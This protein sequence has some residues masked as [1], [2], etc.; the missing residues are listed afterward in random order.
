VVQTQVA[1]YQVGF[2]SL[3]RHEDGMTSRNSAGTKKLLQKFSAPPRQHSR[4]YLD[5]MIQS[6]MVQH[7][8]GRMNCSGLGVLGT[9]HQSADARMH[10]CSSAHGTRL[11]GHEKIAVQQAVIAN[12]GAGL[13]QCQNFGV[14]G[15]IGVGQ[16]A[17]ESASDD[18]PFMHD[19]RAHW[20]FSDVE[21]SLS[22]P[23][24]LL[25]P[26]FVGFRTSAVPHN[27][28]CMRT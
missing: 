12:G 28:Y 1:F 2:R 3:S 14:G 4:T 5:P 25:H 10:D 27:Q 17:V 22:G 11:D 15:W 8:Q 21:R 24:R 16:V 23:Q 26:Q 13:A 20:N 9:V 7:M 6:W 19:N 18:F